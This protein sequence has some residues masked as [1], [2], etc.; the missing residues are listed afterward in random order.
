MSH[1]MSPTELL[2]RLKQFALSVLEI[3]DKL[4]NTHGARALGY[5]SA[6]SAVSVPQNF[7]EAQAASSRK[8][9]ISCIEIAER[10]ARETYVS[11]ELIQLRKYLREDISAV[12]T[13]NDEIIAI[14][15]SI[16]KSTKR[17]NSEIRNPK[18]EF[19]GEAKRDVRI[20]KR[21]DYRKMGHCRA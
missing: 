21:S 9:F 6:R 20:E 4:P 17:N 8:H 2:N 1:K 14:L 10:E 16:G 18:S 13:E 3:A 12:L 19:R 15:T 5:H 7:A 11:L